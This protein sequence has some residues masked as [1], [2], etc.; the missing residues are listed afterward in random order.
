MNIQSQQKKP[1]ITLGSAD[2]DEGT[3]TAGF[4]TGALDVADEGGFF[5]A[6]LV[7]A[8]CISI[9]AA[10]RSFAFLVMTAAVQQNPARTA[11]TTCFLTAGGGH[12]SSN[13]GEDEERW[14]NLTVFSSLWLGCLFSF[15]IF[16]GGG[17]GYA[18]G[19]GEGERGVAPH[20]AG[21]LMRVKEW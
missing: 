7:D 12:T 21:L 20:A 1:C 8:S 13:A 11:G 10:T 3:A 9:F 2:V 19:G 16:G 6:L 5:S 18:C 15:V 17:C 4:F 14:G